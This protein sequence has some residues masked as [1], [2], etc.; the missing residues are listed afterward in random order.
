MMLWEVSCPGFYSCI[1]AVGL[2]VCVHNTILMGYHYSPTSILNWKD[3]FPQ[4]FK[5]ISYRREVRL[6]FKSTYLLGPGFKNTT[7]NFMDGSRNLNS[8]SGLCATW[9][10]NTSTIICTLTSLKLIFIIC[11]SALKPHSPFS[12]PSKS[13]TFWNDVRAAFGSSSFKALEL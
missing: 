6:I 9:T 4:L 11:F 5:Q 13:S 10:Y 2:C 3:S 8:Y 1:Y 7:R 12:P